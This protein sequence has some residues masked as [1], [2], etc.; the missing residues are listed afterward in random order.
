MRVLVATDHAYP[1]QW[2]GG[3]ESS[4]HDVCLAL[5][6]R[7]VEVAVLCRLSWWHPIRSMRPAEALTWVGRRQVRDDTP[8]YPVFRAREPLAAVEDLTRAFQPDVALLQVGRALPLAQRLLTRGVP[9]VVYL[10]DAF[11]ADLGGPITSEPGLTYLTTSEFLARRFAESYGLAAERIPPL[12]RPE[13]YRVEPRR[14]NVTFVCPVPIKGVDIALGLARERR[15]VPFVFL[16]SWP[17]GAAR[18][19]ELRRSTRALGNVSLRRATADMRSVYRDARIVLVPS[20]CDEGWGR[21]VSEGHISGIPA[22]ASARG[23]LPESVGAGGVL[24]DPDASLGA[25]ARA[26]SRLWDDPAE[27][28]RLSRL[29]R[30]HAERA[31]LAPEAIAHR[32]L[33]VL[34]AAAGDHRSIA[35]R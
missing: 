14:R 11:F 32:L 20:R 17:L 21:V 22:L 9:T 3:A 29:A 31:D 34:N 25:W 33:A 19:R 4:I 6:V 35:T 12:V 23:G 28:D 18:R 15:D 1:P 10:R 27:Y 26:L 5:Q 8:G 13:R 16:E 7:G 30:R 24:M 2:M